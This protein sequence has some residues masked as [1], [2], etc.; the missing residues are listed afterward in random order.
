VSG[1]ARVEVWR[2]SILESVHEVCVAV[3]DANGSVRAG[4]GDTQR[5]VFARS[6]VK[7]LQALP[8]VEDGAA[9][10]FEVSEREIALTCASH[11]GEP[12]HV[13]AAAKLLQRI[14]ATE[15][16]LA[17]GAHRPWSAAAAKALRARG[18]APSALHNNCSGKH[19]GMLALARHHGWPLH[20]YQRADHPVQQRV[21]AEIARWT[22]VPPDDIVTAVDGCGILTFALPLASWASAFARFAAAARRTDNGSAAVLRAMVRHP[23][24]VAGTDR[25]CTAL[26]RVAGGRI[27]VKLGAEGVYCAAVPGAE[28]GIALKVVD[29]ARR[30]VEPATV[31]VLHGL[32]LL[33]ADEVA[34]LARFAEPDVLNQR[35]ER[36]GTIRAHIALHVD[37]GP[38]GD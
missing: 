32:G 10:R 21:L 37:G 36:V 7:P 8:L 20:G 22:R 16:A 4:A 12:I 29:G 1:S 11:S 38:S 3:C 2:G 17:C 27:A 25:L 5:T 13:E 15:A 23:E 31:A 14:G 26:M 18:E 24:Y 30:A 35:G 19:A 6:A 9:A 34:E 33:S 28:L